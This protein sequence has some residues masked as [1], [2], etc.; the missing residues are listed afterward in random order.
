METTREQWE[1]VA[2][3]VGEIRSFVVKLGP[4]GAFYLSMCDRVLRMY[5][6]GDRSPALYE[7]MSRIN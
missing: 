4:A 5:D 7:E 2:A 6:A 1:A 3:Q